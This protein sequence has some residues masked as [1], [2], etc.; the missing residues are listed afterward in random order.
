MINLNFQNKCGLLKNI[1]IIYMSSLVVTNR[2]LQS[3]EEAAVDKDFADRISVKYYKNINFRR[4]KLND[5]GKVVEI[6]YFIKPISR[7]DFNS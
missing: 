2:G 3:E 7:S 4:E 6:E 1:N 5:E